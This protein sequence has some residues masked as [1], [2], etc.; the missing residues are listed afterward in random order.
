M[1]EGF[2]Y[3]KGLPQTMQFPQ[4]YRIRE[5]ANRPKA[6][7]QILKERGLWDREQYTSCPK[8]DGRPGCR[9]EGRRCA[10]EILAAGGDFR[11]QKGRL[12]EE[13]EAR[14]HKVIFFPKFHFE[15]NPT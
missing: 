6:L 11:E 15:I 8:S 7:R 5:L 4:N 13:I 2:I 3:S 14:G 10:G 12:Q 9:P 1:R